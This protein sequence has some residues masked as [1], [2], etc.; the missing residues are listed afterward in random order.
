MPRKIYVVSGQL[1]VCVI[2]DKPKDAIAKA[3]QHSDGKTLDGYFFY[4]DERG[5]RTGYDAEFRVPLEKGLKSA[6]FVFDDPTQD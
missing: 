2:A 1:R 3:L 4:L 5:F 6:G